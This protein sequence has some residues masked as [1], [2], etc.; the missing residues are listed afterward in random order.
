MDILD[1]ARYLG[2][3]LLVLGLIGFAGLAA[4]RFGLPGLTKSA[5]TRR[6]K[7]VE[8]LMISPRQRLAIVR[9]D[10]VEH[11]VMIGPEGASVI[12][13][14]ITPPA[15]QSAPSTGPTT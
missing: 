5:A 13:P 11:L 8:T 12:E 3:L 7:I 2:A 6:L 10:D 1:I 4:R 9:R 14:S 15:P